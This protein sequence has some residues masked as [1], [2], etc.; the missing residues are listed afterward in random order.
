MLNNTDEPF[1]NVSYLCLSKPVNN[2][3]MAYSDHFA[4]FL[5]VP[6]AEQVGLGL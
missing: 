4:Y 5:E 3:G 6:D 2:V 1:N